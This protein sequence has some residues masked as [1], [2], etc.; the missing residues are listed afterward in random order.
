[1]AVLRKTGESQYEV[2]VDGKLVGQGTKKEPGPENPGSS[3]SEG[4]PVWPSSPCWLPYTFDLATPER[5]PA[6]TDA[7]IFAR[8]AS[9]GIPAVAISV[10]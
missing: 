2:L 1:M 7:H 3:L 9:E 6:V 10:V 4:V 5:I 8:T